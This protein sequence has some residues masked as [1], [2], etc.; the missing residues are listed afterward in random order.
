[1]IKTFA[2][3][4]NDIVVNLAIAEDV[5]PFEDDPHIE[6]HRGLRLEP[7][8]SYI[9]NEFIDNR[10]KPDPIV[11]VQPTTTGLQKI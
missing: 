5:W 4:E 3:I 1:M 8:W 9:N 11:V 2:K 7:G 6:V 10:P